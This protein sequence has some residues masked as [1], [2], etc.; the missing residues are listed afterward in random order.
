MSDTRLSFGRRTMLA[1]A[2][3]TPFLGR[4]ARA[5]DAQ[6]VVGTWAGDYANLLHANVDEPL[7]VPQNIKV[8]Q[9]LGDEDPRTAKVFAQRMLPRGTDDVICL[10]PAAAYRLNDAKLLE[11]LD[12]TKIP[13]LAKVLPNLRTDFFVPHIYSAQVLIYNPTVVKDPP[14]TYADLLDPKYKGRVGVGDGNYLF[15]MMAAAV[16]GGVDAN[17]VTSPEAQAMAMKLNANGLRLYPSTDSIGAG[18]KTG[19]IDIGIMWLARVAMWQNAA[20]PVA[21]TFPSEGAILYVS[22]MAIPKNAPDKEAAYKYMNA[23]LEPPAQR[24]FAEHMGYLPTVDDAPLTGRIAEQLA[25]P[26]PAPK[27]ITP[28]YAV[29]G[30]VQSDAADWWKRNMQHT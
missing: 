6:V 22:G 8:V 28:D 17:K 19:E 13:N 29:L 24:G 21:S 15:I 3:A 7:V 1:G 4:A 14:K 23:M 20:I 26:T 27:L 18:V 10:A 30:K 11:K 2:A 9:D 25:L 5:E 12:T 16:A